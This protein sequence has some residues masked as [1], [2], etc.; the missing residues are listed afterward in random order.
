MIM[1]MMLGL[2]L[3]FVPSYILVLTVFLF[4]ILIRIQE[5]IKMHHISISVP[6]IS[7]RYYIQWYIIKWCVQICKNKMD[8]HNF[9]NHRIVVQ[10]FIVQ[11]IGGSLL[12]VVLLYIFSKK[13]KC[14]SVLV[15]RNKY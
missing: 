2:I 7:S 12:F 13:K 8:H 14:T 4:F 3:F 1:M 10:Y 11:Y 6:A 5:K 15:C 9:N